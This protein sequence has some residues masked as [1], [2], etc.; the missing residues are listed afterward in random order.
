MGVLG[1]NLGPIQ[2]LKWGEILP[3]D[4]ERRGAKEVR[5]GPDRERA[6]LPKRSGIVDPVGMRETRVTRNLIFVELKARMRSVLP[7]FSCGRS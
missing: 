1:L 5:I 6:S 4:D 3:R 2:I 7:G